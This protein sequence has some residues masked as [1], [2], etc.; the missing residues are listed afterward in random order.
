MSVITPRIPCALGM[1]L[2]MLYAGSC[3]HAPGIADPLGFIRA[4]ILWD[5]SFWI[6]FTQSIPGSTF[7]RCVAVKH[8]NSASSSSIAS[9]NVAEQEK[10]WHHNRSVSHRSRLKLALS[11]MHNSLQTLCFQPRIA[12]TGHPED[13]LRDEGKLSYFLS[14]IV[15]PI[16]P[17][18]TF[19]LCKQPQQWP[20][21]I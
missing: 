5:L 18:S 17:K 12:H 11:V 14:T 6:Q 21:D 19:N 2:W 1:F 15:T 8:G 13:S 16:F 3:K 9:S 4:R 10:W 7:R 20:P